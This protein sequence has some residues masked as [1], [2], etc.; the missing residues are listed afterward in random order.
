MQCYALQK[1]H[2]YQRKLCSFFNKCFNSKS[3]VEK[4]K[5]EKKKW[6]EEATI[7]IHVSK[8]TVCHENYTQFVMRGTNLIISMHRCSIIHCCHDD[9]TFKVRLELFDLRLAKRKK[10]NNV[11]SFIYHWQEC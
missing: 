3:K 4:H 1:S 6:Q 8:I 2:S 9:V 7:Y 5:N 11:Y 10:R